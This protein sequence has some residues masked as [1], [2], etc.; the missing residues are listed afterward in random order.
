MEGG[1][2]LQRAKMDA[3]NQIKNTGGHT[4]EHRK[5]HRLA[6]SQLGKKF[7]PFWGFPHF[8]DSPYINCIFMSTLIPFE[9]MVRF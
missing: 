6:V 8:G 4:F 2:T 1:G 5:T 9:P 7:P 3:L